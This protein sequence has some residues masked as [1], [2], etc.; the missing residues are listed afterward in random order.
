MSQQ[1]FEKRGPGRPPKSVFSMSQQVGEPQKKK[2][3]L[4]QSYTFGGDMLGMGSMSQQPSSGFKPKG[5]IK[6]GD[7]NE[8]KPKAKLMARRSM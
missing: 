4:Q 1:A 7:K 8:K 3:K 5:V 6:G 2:R